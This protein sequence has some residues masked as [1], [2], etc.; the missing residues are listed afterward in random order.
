MRLV[1]GTKCGGRAVLVV[2]RAQGDDGRAPK[3]VVTRVQ[4]DDV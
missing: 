1:C 2:C 3:R 4:G